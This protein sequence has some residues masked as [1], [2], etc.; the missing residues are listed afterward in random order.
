MFNPLIHKKPYGATVVGKENYIE[1]P[2]DPDFR[3]KRVRFI[4]RKDD[5]SYA[6]EMSKT[7]DGVF[8]LNFKVSE[9][10]IWYYRFE[11]DTDG[12]ILYFGQGEDGVAICG[13]WLPEWQL[14]VS[15][16]DYRTPQWAKAGIIYHI[17]ADRF[18]KVGDNPFDKDGTLHKDWYE[19]PVVAN[20]GEEYRADDFFG[21]NIKGIISKLDYLKSLGV[22]I[23]YLS[24]VFESFSNHRYDTADYFKIDPLFGTEEEFK[25]LIKQAK[26]RGMYIM[27]DGVF[28]HTGSDSI[29]FNKKGRYPTLGAYQS[30]ESPYYD[31]YYFYDYPDSY[32]CWWGSTVVPTVNKSSE[33]YRKMIFGKG[34]V[35]DKWT[36]LGVKGWRL[37]VV[38][39]LPIDFVNLIRSCVKKIDSECLIIG[40]VWED[41]ST[42]VAYSQWR[43]YFMGE[44]LD[45]VMN[46]PFKEAILE[47][48][49]RGDVKK[50]KGAL[51]KIM[52]NYPKQSLDV[53][54]NMLDSHDTVR[55]LNTLAE[56]PIDGTTKRER[57]EIKIRGEFLDRAKLRLKIALSLLYFLPGNPCVYYGDEAGLTGYED[58]M[59]RKTYPWGFEDR[60]ILDFYTK[61]GH[62]R[63]ML[64]EE[65]LGET[66]FDDD[67]EIVH[68]VRVNGKK[69]ADI[70]VNNTP[71]HVTRQFD[72]DAINMLDERTCHGKITIEPYDFA[73]L[74]K[75]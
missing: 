23:I 48:S 50:L 68:I 13:E 49:M 58:P 16:I 12:G 71:N 55:V 10:G 51:S 32:H 36:S 59:N 39:E 15:K 74:K 41:A 37:D 66:Y 8:F 1:F 35:F 43:P 70:F 4:L 61:L 53:L 56:Y 7:Q 21:G 63:S 52:Q 34:G 33:S 25:D 72:F 46:Y 73:V 6:Y 3:V 5:R 64:K 18:C 14:T 17:F 54:L 62:V 45:G 19:N 27:L 11:A 57:L 9:Y 44:Q 67:N 31:W 40:E 42:K 38:D 47:F 22:T 69:R 75:D 20:Q 60:E 24:P 26:E 30:K 29:Y 28:N 65:M 2:L